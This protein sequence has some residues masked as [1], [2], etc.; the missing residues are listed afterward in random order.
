MLMLNEAALLMSR[1]SVARA[2]WEISAPL[3]GIG[4]P[5]FLG[6]PLLYGYYRRRVKLPRSCSA[7]PPSTAFYTPVTLCWLHMAR[8]GTTF[9][10][11]MN[12]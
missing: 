4:F 9:G 3:F 6:G 2:R 7:W 11:R 10:Q 1:S 8:Q 5:P 12:G